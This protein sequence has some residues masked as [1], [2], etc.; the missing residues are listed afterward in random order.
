MK[1][2]LCKTLGLPDTLV[3]EE[4]ADLQPGPGQVLV[5]MKAAG[6]NAVTSVAMAVAVMATATIG[7][8]D[9][10]CR[11]DVRVAKASASQ[12]R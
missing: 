1:A 6:V 7:D 3:Y 12:R 10:K 5:D 2:L 8:V 11:D 9:G 4:T